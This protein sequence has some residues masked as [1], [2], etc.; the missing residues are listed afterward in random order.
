[1]LLSLALS[2]LFDSKFQEAEN[3]LKDGI[4]YCEKHRVGNFMVSC[5]ILLATILIAKG[6]MK[7]GDDMME[8]A[9]EKLLRKQRKTTFAISEYI[10]G[11]IYFQIATGPTPSFSMISKNLW[12][13]IKNAPFAGRNAENSLFRAIELFKQLGMKGY[14]G[15]SYLILGMLYKDR[16]NAEEAKRYLM[17]A[18]NLFE[19]CEAQGYMERAN[20]ALDS[21]KIAD[22]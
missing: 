20:D 17:D 12:F 3:C 7:Q 13:L 1:M 11:E 19:K 9:R 16:K 2:F 15:K 14:L 4:N 5:Q 21:L 22:M 6:Y 10:V 18:I 8:A